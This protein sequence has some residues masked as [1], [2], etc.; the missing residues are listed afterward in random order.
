M[1][2]FLLILSLFFINNCKAENLSYE[3]IDSFCKTTESI[4]K[5]IQTTRQ[6]GYTASYTEEE[7]LKLNENITKDADLKE[8]LEVVIHATLPTA[9][10]T[11]MVETKEEKLIVIEKFGKEIYLE[12]V[13]S[14]AGK[15]SP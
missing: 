5:F 11:E 13:M 12:C 15:V 10:I 7:A 6:A 1:N 14:F 4:A 3:S 8:I 9:Y 2:K